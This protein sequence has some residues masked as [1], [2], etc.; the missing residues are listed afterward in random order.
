VGLKSPRGGSP[1]SVGAGIRQEVV[2]QASLT[3]RPARFL[4]TSGLFMRLAA[5][6]LLFAP[7]L[8]GE[9]GAKADLIIGEIPLTTTEA[10][11]GG[12]PAGGSTVEPTGGSVT[13]AGVGGSSTEPIGGTSDAGGSE[14]A[15][16]AGMAGD[17]G[18]DCAAGAEPPPD[19]LIH[20]YSFDGTGTSALDSV[21]AMPADGSVVGTTLDGSGVVSMN[22]KSRQYVDL[23]NGI[24]SSLTDLTVVTWMTWSGGAAYQRVFDFGSSDKGEGVGGSGRSYLAVLPMT[25]FE[26][27]AKPG[28]GAELKSPGFPTVTLASTESMKNRAAQVSLVFRSGVNA[29]LY[30]DGNLLVSKATTIT[31]ADIDDRNNWL[32]QSQFQTDPAFQGSYQEFRIYDVAL[33]GCQLHTLLVRGPESP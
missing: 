14:S 16:S 13:M 30:L 24:V 2:F 25:G 21:T 15:G 5:L 32:G 3:A 22:G 20:R 1:A 23:P 8:L 17:G 12:T 27:Q 18:G 4:L 29:E 6:P 19:S 7:L 28:L 11:T 31:L 9:C 10:G 33:D 26:N